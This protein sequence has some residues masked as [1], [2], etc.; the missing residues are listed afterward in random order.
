LIVECVPN[1]SEGRDPQIVDR[2]A[3]AVARTPGAFLL[4]KSSDP[5]HNRSVLTFVGSPTSIEQAAFEAI[6]AAV[7]L[8]DITRHSGVHP[9]LGAADVVPFVPIHGVALDRCAEIATCLADRLWNELRLPSYF[10]E[11]AARRPEC[12]R[13]ENIRRL[14]PS[15]LAPDIGEGRHPTAGVCVVGARKFLIAWNVILLTSDLTAAKAVAREVRESS[16]GLPALKALGLPLPSRNRVQVS[17]N[18]VD[19]EITPLHLAFDAVAK[20]CQRRDV[21]IEGSELIGMIPAAALDATTGHNLRWL[22]LRPESVI[23]NR[24]RGLNVF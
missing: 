7:D 11:A 12:R 24:L 21:E 23:E 8:I 18:L 10:Y 5:D 19:F 2:I 1:F 6:R 22:N 13:L 16:G 3:A 14:A 15:D 20:S 17:M 9:R 4:D